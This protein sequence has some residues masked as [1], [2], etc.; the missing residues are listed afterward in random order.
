M[1][2]PNEVCA[3]YLLMIEAYCADNDAEPAASVGMTFGGGVGTAWLPSQLS[4]SCD[5]SDVVDETVEKMLDG[6]IW[7]PGMVRYSSEIAEEISD[8]LAV[9]RFAL[10]QGFVGARRE[11]RMRSVKCEMGRLLDA[12]R[13]PSFY[14]WS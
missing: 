2:V 14:T 7:M 8:I 6:M 10:G 12:R 13:A 9:L 1:T 4:G 11:M 3:G 5:C